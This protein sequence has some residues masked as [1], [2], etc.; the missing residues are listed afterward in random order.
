MDYAATYPK[1]KLYFFARNMILHV[2]SDTVYLA[3]DNARSRISGYYILS[4]YPE[5]A[6]TIPQSAPNAPILFECKTL[7]SVVASAAEA[8][9]GDLFHN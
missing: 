8:K 9:T 7:Q 2:D 4:F 6:L 3:Q 1:A 5:P